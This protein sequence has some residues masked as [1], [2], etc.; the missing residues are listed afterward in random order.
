MP[1]KHNGLISFLWVYKITPKFSTLRKQYRASEGQ[2]FQGSLAGWFWL[3][4]TWESSCQLGL[5]W[6]EGGSTSKMVDSPGWQVD[7]GSWQA[8]P[9]PC[10]MDLSVG[11]YSAL[12]TWCWLPPHRAVWA[13]AWQN[14]QHLLWQGHTPSFSQCSIVYEGWRNMPPQNMTLWPKN[15][16]DLK[17]TEKRQTQ[18]NLFA[19][20]QFAWRTSQ[21]A[22]H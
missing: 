11:P 14:P 19:L 20:P 1:R 5:Q 6:L 16:L 22:Q 21:L 13:R 15:Y 12:M 2:E 9:V 8:A 4:W 7:A 18:E 10:H 17:A 3:S